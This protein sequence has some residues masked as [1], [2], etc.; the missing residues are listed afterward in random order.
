MKKMKAN[1]EVTKFVIISIE[2][3][4]NINMLGFFLL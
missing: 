4:P 2:K 3:K 1:K